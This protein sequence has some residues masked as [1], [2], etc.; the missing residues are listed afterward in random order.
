M[1]GHTDNAIVHQAQF[2]GFQGLV[3]IKTSI[4]DHAGLQNESVTGELKV[5][6]SPCGTTTRMKIW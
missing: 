1:S 4:T 5:P 2:V 3:H 6:D